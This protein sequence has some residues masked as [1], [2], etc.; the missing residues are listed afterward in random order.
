MHNKILK[1]VFYNICILALPGKFF[2]SV[3]A[4]GN[5]A[6]LYSLRL[7]WSTCPNPKRYNLSCCCGDGKY[8][9]TSWLGN[10]E[11]RL[12]KGRKPRANQQQNY[13]GQ[14]S[15]WAQPWIQ[16][17]VW[18][19]RFKVIPGQGSWVES[20]TKCDNC[21]W[22][23]VDRPAWILL[24]LFLYLWELHRIFILALCPHYL[25]DPTLTVITHPWC[26]PAPFVLRN[27]EVNFPGQFV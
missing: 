16:Y 1:E 14:I 4:Y 17:P 7:P 19:W 15:V 3:S 9:E 5:L 13:P 21:R 18:V 24:T 27:M 11:L 26:S 22:E 10:D 25:G 20:E 6:S 23:K 8:G 2:A 12:Q